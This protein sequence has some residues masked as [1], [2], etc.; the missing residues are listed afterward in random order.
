MSNVLAAF[1]FALGVTLMLIAFAPGPLADVFSRPP[2]SKNL[3]E[4]LA[5]NLRLAG[6]FDQTP[7]FIVIALLGVMLGVGVVLGVLT[8][9]VFGA[10]AAIPLVPGIAHYML[11]TRQ[12]GFLNR[13][14]GELGPF[15]NRIATSTRAGKPVQAAYIEGVEES[16]ELRRI[17]ADSAAKM[18]AGMRFREA[19]VET[20][21]LLP[22]RMWSVFVRQLEA[23]DEG[24]GDLGT[25]IDDTIKQTNEVLMLHAEARAD[26]A[27]QSKQQ[28]LIVAIAI[29]G[30]AFFTVAVDPAIMSTLWTTVAGFFSMA[31]A[32]SIMGFGLWFSRKQLRDI[33]QKQAF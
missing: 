28:K 31:I 23:H 32:G 30:V 27:T 16:R 1:L 9:S 10:L 19:L 18:T 29:G 33:E 13:A 6:I 21:P 20:I 22:F 26:Y 14:S 11:M 15:L 4:H 2:K 12:R 5:R 25:A 24:G 17:L 7:T 3:Q 8:G